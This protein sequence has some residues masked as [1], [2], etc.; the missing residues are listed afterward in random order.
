MDCLVETWNVQQFVGCLTFAIDD[1]MELPAHF[2]VWIF[3]KQMFEKGKDDGQENWLLCW[4][5]I[6]LECLTLL[7]RTLN[8]D[9][10][11]FGSM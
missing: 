3:E 6:C 2:V 11:G 8:W 7:T 1:T 10:A 5:Y 9:L 4:R